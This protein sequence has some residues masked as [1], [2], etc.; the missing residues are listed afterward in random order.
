MKSVKKSRYEFWPE[1]SK[2]PWCPAIDAT[3]KGYRIGKRMF[4]LSY[5]V[6]ADKGIPVIVVPGKGIEVAGTLTLRKSR[7]WTPKGCVIGW[8]PKR[9][10]IAVF[11][12]KGRLWHPGHK[13]HGKDTS[14][15]IAAD[16]RGY[17]VSQGSDPLEA[18]RS[19]LLTCGVANE[20]AREEKRR[21]KRVTRQMHHLDPEVKKDMKEMEEKARNGGIILDGVLV[22]PTKI[23]EAQVS[24]RKRA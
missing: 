22:P 9:L 19:L 6:Y 5:P 10:K 21:G 1:V 20:E 12:E 24:K 23:I 11:L 17:N 8:V 13:D 3:I 16:V 4:R 18:I 14:G 7:P 15:W 2:K